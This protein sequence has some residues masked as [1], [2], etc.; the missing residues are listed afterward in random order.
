MRSMY[1]FNPVDLDSNPPGGVQL[2]SREFLACLEAGSDIVVQFPVRTRHR[3]RARLLRRCGAAPYSS[4]VPSD[5]AKDLERVVHEESISHIFI[6][7]AELMRFAGLV[8]ALNLP[9]KTVL[10]SHGNQS[11]DDLS[12]AM[13]HD[14]L[15][16]SGA[17]KAFRLGRHLI[18]ESEHR[19]DCIDGVCVMSHEERTFEQWLGAKEI[20]VIPRLLDSSPIEWKPTLGRVGYS[21][22]LSHPPNRRALESICQDL[23]RR[24]VRNIEIRVVG[25][26]VSRGTELAASYPFVR[27]LGA[28]SNQE[29]RAEAS[30]WSAV[31]NPLFGLA[32]GASMKLA[33]GLGLGLPVI[34]TAFGA[35]GY[36]FGGANFPTTG[37]SPGDFVEAMLEIVSGHQPLQLVA[38]ACRRAVKSAPTLQDIGQRIR[39]F[40]VRLT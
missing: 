26:P 17:I 14:R 4:Y 25:Q 35:R 21:G 27:Y 7:K 40:A 13:G 33:A 12:D 8:R 30:T 18:V 38:E 5:Y 16:L 10:M 34:S 39:E 2:C 36:E 6:N 11:G 31:L 29:L 20:V 22:T 1:I 28:L 23:R 24:A 19:R 3:R 15:S 37:N 32:R 9:V